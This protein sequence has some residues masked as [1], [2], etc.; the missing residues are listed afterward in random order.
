ME[1][2]ALDEH[3]RGLQPVI[4]R[5][6][7]RCGHRPRVAVH[8][9]YQGTYVYSFVQPHSG[10]SHWLILPRV[11][12]QVFTLALEHFAREVG[13]GTGKRVVV[14]VAQAGYPTSGKVRV[15]TGITLELLPAYSP[16]LQPAER[17]WPLTNEGV[18][19]KRFANIDEL[20]EALARRCVVLAEHPALLRAYTRYHWWP[21][22][23]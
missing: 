11:T 6:W 17:L 14:V 3:R 1:L 10:A 20:E 2:W 21:D 9:R 16:E 7:A 15:P 4:R 22:A 5:V 19:N 18:A 8:H 13:A 23:A 12:A